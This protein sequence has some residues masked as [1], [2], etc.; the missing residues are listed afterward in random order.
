M[1]MMFDA[2]YTIKDVI[3]DYVDLN[4][5]LDHHFI[6]TMWDEWYS[7]A[8]ESTKPENREAL[9]TSALSKTVSVSDDPPLQSNKER[10]ASSNS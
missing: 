3:K 6:N 9:N 1:I 4:R 5:E 10:P 2:D 8:V 7:P